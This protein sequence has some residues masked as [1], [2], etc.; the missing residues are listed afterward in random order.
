MGAMPEIVDTTDTEAVLLFESSIPLACSVVYGK[1]TAYGQI[2]VDQDMAGGA[3]TDHHPLLSGLE[4]DSEYHV[5]GF[6]TGYRLL[7][8]VHVWSPQ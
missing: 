5:T 7:I 2:S 3:H 1:T 8:A 6:I 4:P